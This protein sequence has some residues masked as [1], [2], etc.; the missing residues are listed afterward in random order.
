MDLEKAYINVSRERLWKVL[1]EYP[2]TRDP[3]GSVKTGQDRCVCVC[4]FILIKTTL[5]THL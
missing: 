3:M 5:L 4:M 1:E 2:G